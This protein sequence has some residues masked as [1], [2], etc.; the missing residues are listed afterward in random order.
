MTRDDAITIDPIDTEHMFKLLSLDVTKK[1]YSLVALN[2]EGDGL[3]HVIREGLNEPQPT[4]S[5]RAR[6]D[7]LFAI[8]RERLGSAMVDVVRRWAGT[9]F[10]YAFRAHHVYGY[11]TVLLAHAR[12]QPAL[13]EALALP[14]DRRESFM[15][16]FLSAQEDDSF[17]TAYE[18]AI[19]PRLSDWDLQMKLNNEFHDA[20]SD[21]S[22]PEIVLRSLASLERN[23]RFWQWVVR[24]LAP[25]EVDAL[26]ASAN[27][28][29]KRTPQFAFIDEDLR[30]PAALA[31]PGGR[32]D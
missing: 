22:G 25:E 1:L 7:R 10:H 31:S 23:R 18:T 20:D 6:V 5:T 9:A 2:I 28:L 12:W 14:D 13:R 24:T 17:E 16:H 29:V 27:A 26:H 19:A 11:W 4:D 21:T 32:R 8:V 15:A 30:H 3:M